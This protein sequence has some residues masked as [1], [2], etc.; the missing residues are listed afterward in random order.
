MRNLLILAAA[1]AALLA[2]PPDQ[3]QAWWKANDYARPAANSESAGQVRAVVS[4]G[5]WVIPQFVAGGGWGT[6]VSLVNLSTTAQNYTIDFWTDEGGVWRAPI[7]QLGRVDRIRGALGPG[8]CVTYETDAS[9]SLEQGWATVLPGSAESVGI[10]GFAVFRQRVPGRPDF[11]AVAPMSSIFDKSFVLLY[12]NTRGFSTGAALVNAH[13]QTA[14]SVQAF[15]RDEAG[16]VLTE[17]T[18]S[19]PP[20]G[21]TAFSL[22]DRF[23][24]TAG[25]RGSVVFRS[26][27]MTLSGL[28]LRFNPSGAF[29]SFH[30]L[31]TAEMR[32]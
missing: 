1:T 23:P 2:Q 32:R 17:Q 7:L 11:E 13:P 31:N 27:G 18:I 12:D 9:V 14:V 16:V 22:P 29:T 30:A 19:L 24:L 28:G 4:I 20:L 15:F 6:A 26:S 3:A 10:G 25:K 8:Q 21:H 5:D